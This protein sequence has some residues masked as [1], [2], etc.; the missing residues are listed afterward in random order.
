ME[1][2]G[3]ESA[4]AR[5]GGVARLQN[6]GRIQ[7]K[8]DRNFLERVFH[9]LL[10]NFT[11]W[12]N[13]KD[14]EGK[15]VFQGGFLGLT[16][17]AF[18]TARGRSGRE[19][20]IEQSDGTS[21]MAMYC[22]DMLAM[23]IEL[24]HDDPAYEDVASKFFEHFVYISQAMNDMG[25]EGIGLWDEKD[26][27]YYD[28]LHLGGRRAHIPMKVR[29]MVG[30]I[31]LFA[32]ET[33]EPEDLAALAGFHAPHAV[34]S[35]SSPGRVRA[36]G[37]EPE[38]REWRAVAADDRQS[39]E[40]GANLSLRFR[41]EGISF[42]PWHSGAFEI[43]SRSSVRAQRGRTAHSVDYEPGESTTDL[44]GGNSNW[45]GPVWFPLNFL[46]IE[47]MQRV[48][49]LLRRRIQGGVPDRLGPEENA[50][51]CGERTFA[52]AF[53]HFSSRR[54]EAGRCT[55]I[56]RSFSRILSGAI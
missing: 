21:W 11:W 5:L 33:F 43:S 27:F 25:G 45:R 42:A 19:T 49:Y 14:P 38:H 6:C 8:P 26:G 41:R 20:T 36:R 54:W 9:K 22:L 56:R 4:G 46:L 30:L 50:L 32:V 12:V 28:V 10:L 40:A 17:S 29:S 24:A 16:T 39:E 53:A 37:H 47:S 34:V 31:P 55:A 44:F 48:H 1:F 13:R 23:A 52:P 18:S 7:G 51:E 35:R 15:N 3:R 2:F